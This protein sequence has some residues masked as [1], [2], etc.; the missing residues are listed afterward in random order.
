ML[1]LFFFLADINDTTNDQLHWGWRVGAIDGVFGDFLVVLVNMTS[2]TVKD[3]AEWS[4][5]RKLFWS[6]NC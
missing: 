1:L 3:E 4:S 5:D 2:L 6:E